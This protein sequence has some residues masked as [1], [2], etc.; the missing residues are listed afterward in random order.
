MRGSGPS[1]AEVGD[2][3]FAEAERCVPRC[4]RTHLEGD[5]YGDGFFGTC[6]GGDGAGNGWHGWPLPRVDGDGG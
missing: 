4:W 5:G 3:S 6:P 2:S 1:I